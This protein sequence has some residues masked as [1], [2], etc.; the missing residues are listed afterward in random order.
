MSDSDEERA[1]GVQLSR[2]AVNKG[3]VEASAERRRVGVERAERGAERRRRWITGLGPD[4]S[5]DLV[6]RPAVGSPQPRGEDSSRN[7]Y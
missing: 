7:S 5:V 6:W 4:K 2:R 3:V 1:L